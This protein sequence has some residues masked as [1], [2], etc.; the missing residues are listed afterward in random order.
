QQGRLEEADKLAR[1]SLR[2]FT[3]SG[4]RLHTAFALGIVGQIA[5]REGRHSDAGRAFT[6]ALNMA[7][8]G[9]DLHEEIG[10]LGRIAED[11][12]LR[13]EGHAALSVADSTLAR[14]EPVGGAGD[15]APL[16]YR[17]R[18]YALLQAGDSDG[19]ARA[20]QE[21]IDQARVRG[22]EH[23][24]ALSLL[25]QQALARSHGEEPDGGIEAEVRAIFARL[26]VSGELPSPAAP[27]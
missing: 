8:E 6:R 12:V 13:G 24:V 23:E 16:L 1:E 20:F 7:Q 4:Y 25:G 10:V 21:S 11:L 19:A 27:R 3:A 26:G 14:A 9:G 15:N 18:G 22:S 2:T 17:V 5:S